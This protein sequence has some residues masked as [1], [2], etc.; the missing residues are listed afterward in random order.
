MKRQYFFNMAILTK[1]LIISFFILYLIACKQELYTN[2]SEVEANE[3]LSVLLSNG[4]DAKKN[5]H[6]DGTMSISIESQSIPLAVNLLKQNGL[7]RESHPEMGEVFKKEGLISSPL[8]E[9]VRYL[10][11]L[12]ESISETLEKIDGVITARVHIVLPDN[13]AFS[14][15]ITPASASIY[16]KYNPI[17]KLEDD[18]SKI[19]MIVETSISGL[20]YDKISLVMLPAKTNATNI[21][22]AQSSL[23]NQ[24]NNAWLWVL[25]FILFASTIGSLIWWIGGKEFEETLPFNTSSTDTEYSGEYEEE[26]K[27]KDG[28]DLQKI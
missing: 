2:L 8:E 20:A 10:Y 15:T 22:M 7:P 13:D 28:T 23:T 17:Y 14:E 19:K 4:V 12:S 3:M 21:K 27:Q 24:S 18:A 25:G 6:T 5:P 16:I 26:I 11:A 1:P 9:K